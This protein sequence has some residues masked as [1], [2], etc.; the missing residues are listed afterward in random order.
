MRMDFKNKKGLSLMELLFVIAIVGIMS[1]IVLNSLSASRAK[2][3]DAKVQMQ[4]RG[5]RAAAENYYTSQSPVTY[6]SAN[7][8]NSGMFVDTDPKHGSPALY[9]ASSAL[10]A[11]TQ[12]FCGSTDGTN[13][14]SSEFAV[15]ASLSKPGQYWCVDNKG[16]AG[17]F[18]GTPNNGL[19]S[20]E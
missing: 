9:L 11:G 15:I 4:L 18:S 14:V 20:C 13:G 17:L 8:C 19:T 6:G 3:N 7:D 10:P 5:F 16:F 1:T 2:S 12:V